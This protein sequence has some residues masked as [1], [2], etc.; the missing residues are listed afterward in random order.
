MNSKTTTWN[1]LPERERHEPSEPRVTFSRQT[2]GSPR[3]FFNT[4]ACELIK[5]SIGTRLQLLAP[6]D[7]KGS[8]L[9][10]LRS[11]ST[12]PALRK[13]GNTRSLVLVTSALPHFAKQYRK[14]QYRPRAGKD[15]E[16]QW[17]LEPIAS[18]KGAVE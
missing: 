7:V 13:S 18:E 16:P 17:V 6:A 12:G 11:A 2:K 4:K 3:V 10:G 8:P 1:V 15:T 5:L 9:I 14:I